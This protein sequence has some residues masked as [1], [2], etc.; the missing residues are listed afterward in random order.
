MSLLVILINTS[1]FKIRLIRLKLVIHIHGTWYNNMIVNIYAVFVFNY[2]QSG[3][4]YSHSQTK[5]INDPRSPRELPYHA[6]SMSRRFM[7]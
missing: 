4:V 7:N 6:P 1:L 3:V 2:E 5:T